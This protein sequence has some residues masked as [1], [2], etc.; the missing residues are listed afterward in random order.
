[1]P[2]YRLTL[3]YDGSAYNG[4]QA[5]TDQPTVQGSVEAA[6]TAFCGETVRLA[7]AGRTD[8]GV[9]AT[10]QVISLDLEKAWPAQTVMNALNAHLVGEAI[11]V[12]D[13]EGVEDDWHARFSATGRRYLYRILNRPGPPALDAGRVWHMRKSMDADAMHAAAQTLVGLHDFTTFRDVNCQSKSPEKTLDVASVRRVGDE[14]HLVF[15]ARSFLHRQVRSMTGTLAEVGLGRWTIDDVATALAA[16]DRAACG[17]V[18][19]S[20]GL[21]LTGVRY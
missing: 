1:M 10:G 18:A 4:F 12:L 11:S 14:V 16:R 19:P 7:A 9:H 21:Y 20:T 5:Q 8:T 3:E 17:P 13:C 2:R 6:I 15:E